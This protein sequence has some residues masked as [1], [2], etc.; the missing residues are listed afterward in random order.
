[1]ST[2]AGLGCCMLRAVRKSSHLSTPWLVAPSTTC[3]CKS[4]QVG[5]NQHLQL[6]VCTRAERKWMLLWGS[7]PSLQEA[8]VGT[9]YHSM[10]L[11]PRRTCIEVSTW[12]AAVLWSARCLTT[13]SMPHGRRFSC[14]VIS[15][16]R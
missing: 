7:Q 13:G 1:M 14:S 9:C 16:C 8:M 10:W 5:S 4:S 15:A 2:A 3:T 6:T 12:K 11:M